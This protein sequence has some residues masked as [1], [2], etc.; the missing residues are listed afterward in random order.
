MK[1]QRRHKCRGCGEL[2]HPDY[3]NRRHQRYCRDPECRLAS[4]RARQ[5]KWRAS[6][7]GRDYFHG[8]TH[9]LRVK[10]WRQEHPGHSRRK[11]P[12]SRPALQ[13]VSSPQPADSQAVKPELIRDPLQDV[14]SAQP[15]VL[16][17]LVSSLT[18]TALQDDIASC[19]RRFHARGQ[20]ILDGFRTGGAGRAAPGS[21]AGSPRKE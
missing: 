15:A 20:Q 17:G 14:C 4:K 18:G 10:Q 2:Y 5:A 12:Q 8:P 3:R 1:Q 6:D 11:A 16:V 21:T 9:V 13:D 7:K 19:L